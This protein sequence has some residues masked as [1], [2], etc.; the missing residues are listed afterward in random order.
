MLFSAFCTTFSLHI[1]SC[2]VLDPSERLGAEPKSSPDALRAH[3]FFSVDESAQV[4]GGD[5][6]HWEALWTN[7]SVQPETGI[8]PPTFRDTQEDGDD[9]PWDNVVHEFSLA[10]ITSPSNSPFPPP[11]PI[12]VPPD[13]VPTEVTET[14]LNGVDHESESADAAD[15]ALS[16]KDWY[17]LTGFMGLSFSLICT[18]VGVLT[19]SESVRRTVYTRAS[20]RWGLLKQTRPCMLVLTSQP[21]IICVVP[22]EKRSVHTSANVKK[23]FTFTGHSNNTIK[24][25]KYLIV[26]CRSDESQKKLVL[27]TVSPPSRL[28]CTLESIPLTVV[29]GGERVRIRIS[30]SR[31][32]TSLAS[33]GCRPHRSFMNRLVDNYRNFAYIVKQPLAVKRITVVL[34]SSA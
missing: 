7:P 13:V 25:D 27:Q 6:I 9:D 33:R 3:R 29:L 15:L 4:D 11:P 14:V 10:N 26:S 20:F 12:D 17:V 5:A 16:T 1:N 22:D 18:R 2:Q 8:V 21:R 34:S 28:Y 30:R 31:I 24:G 23:S 19:P 32:S